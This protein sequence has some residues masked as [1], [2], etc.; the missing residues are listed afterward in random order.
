MLRVDVLDGESVEGSSNPACGGKIYGDA[1]ADII[2][3]Q[4]S[5]AEIDRD[6][7]GRGCCCNAIQFE[8]RSGDVDLRIVVI[9]WE[10]SAFRVVVVVVSVDLD[11]GLGVGRRGLRDRETSAGDGLDVSVVVRRGRR[12]GKGLSRA[13]SAAADQVDLKLTAKAH[14]LRCDT[15]ALRADIDFG[16]HA[17]VVSRD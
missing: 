4:S 8:S 6:A 5:A 14:V 13:L 2:K 1:L 12:V 17:I 7:Q 15:Q 16:L 10:S 3:D 11:V 9:T